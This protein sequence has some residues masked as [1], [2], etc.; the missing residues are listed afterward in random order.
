MDSLKRELKDHAE[1][2]EIQQDQIDALEDE[3]E[4]EKELSEKHAI[5]DLNELIWAKVEFNIA[6]DQVIDNSQL[7]DKLQVHFIFKLQLIKIS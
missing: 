1:L 6:N 7:I 3:I 2:V 5:K 4:H